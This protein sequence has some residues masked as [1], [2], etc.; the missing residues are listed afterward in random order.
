M[1]SDNRDSLAKVAVPFLA[2][3]S[4]LRLLSLKILLAAT[5]ENER[6]ARYYSTEM[7]G[8]ARE[9]IEDAIGLLNTPT[10][11]CECVGDRLS[12]AKTTT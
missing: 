5:G 10:V 12:S 7:A 4:N 3:Y 6:D 9:A 1:F 11:G 2:T 8:A